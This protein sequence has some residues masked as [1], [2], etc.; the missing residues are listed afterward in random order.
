VQISQTREDKPTLSSG[1]LAVRLLNPANFV[2]SHLEAG[3]VEAP[4]PGLD[5]R[6]VLEHQGARCA[7]RDAGN[8]EA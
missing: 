2:A 3:H 8:G 5:Q 7:R 1:M 4:S 6:H